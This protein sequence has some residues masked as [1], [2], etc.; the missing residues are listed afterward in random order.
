ML[1]DISIWLFCDECLQY[2]C[3]NYSEDYFKML[4]IL[5]QRM[6]EFDLVNQIP[7]LAEQ[8]IEKLKIIK[9]ERLLPELV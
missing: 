4:S 7:L 9:E 5:I 1:N 6:L 2:M 8:V 3:K